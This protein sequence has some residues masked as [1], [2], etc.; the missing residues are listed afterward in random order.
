MGC[1]SVV[2]FIFLTIFQFVT[3]QE[4]YV[5]TSIPNVLGTIAIVNYVPEKL[6]EIFCPN[7]YISRNLY[8]LTKLF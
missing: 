2:Y 4:V 7:V 8:L 5:I 6:G 1:I 3:D